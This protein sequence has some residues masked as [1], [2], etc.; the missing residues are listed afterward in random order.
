MPFYP[1]INNLRKKGLISQRNYKFNGK[2]ISLNL[3]KTPLVL[4][5]FQPLT[6]ST[7]NEIKEN[8]GQVSSYTHPDLI[9]TLES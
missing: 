3:L 6:Y 8:I 5:N 1:I 2:L 9:K 4:N 7:K